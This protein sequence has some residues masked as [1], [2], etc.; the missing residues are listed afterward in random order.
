M[1]IRIKDRQTEQRARE[2]ARLT[3]ETIEEAV[4][5]AIRERLTRKRMLMAKEAL[6]EELL[7]IGRRCASLP[8]LDDRSEDEILGLGDR[9]PPG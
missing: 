1:A 9:R 2:L 3:G 5:Q 6:A 8:A 7:A 4:R